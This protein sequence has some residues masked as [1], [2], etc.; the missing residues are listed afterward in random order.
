VERER[1]HAA[2]AGRVEEWTG[3]PK[4]LEATSDDNEPCCFPPCKAVVSS[5]SNLGPGA[6]LGRG[7]LSSGGAGA[8]FPPLREGQRQLEPCF[9]S[10]R[11]AFGAEL[12]LNLEP[13]LGLT[14]GVE[15]GSTLGVLVQ[16]P[17]GVVRGEEPIGTALWM[18]G[19]IEVL[20][21]EELIGVV[22]GEHV[23]KL[24]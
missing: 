21:R 17:I 18:C 5:G 12:G 7:R 1:E 9:S 2:E 10:A 16:E 8:I 19:G 3:T 22:A 24:A 23:S 13:E 14:A 4:R 15:L 11:R 20:E 6:L